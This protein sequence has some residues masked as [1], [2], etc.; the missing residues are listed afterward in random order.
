MVSCCACISKTGSSAGRPNPNEPVRLSEPLN[1]RPVRRSKRTGPEAVISPLVPLREAIAEPSSVAD[2]APSVA[3]SNSS[4]DDG[5]SSDAGPKAMLPHAA[6]S[7][8]L[9]RSAPGFSYRRLI[10][11]SGHT[12]EGSVSK[13]DGNSKRPSR[14]NEKPCTGEKPLSSMV[15]SPAIV[16]SMSPADSPIASRGSAPGINE[17]AS[18]AP[19]NMPRLNPA[20]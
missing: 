14:S 9:P 15:S 18:S 17:K 20:L 6:K 5:N 16:E 19:V 2:C 10:C 11:M 12:V 13:K 3:R 4:V 8:T 7:E 1:S